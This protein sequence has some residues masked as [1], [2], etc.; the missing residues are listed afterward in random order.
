MVRSAMAPDR[1]PRFHIVTFFTE[2]A[3]FDQGIDLADIERE[4]RALVEP[5]VDSYR[6]YAPRVLADDG[7]GASRLVADYRG[8]LDQHPRRSELGN[9]NPGWARIGFLA[10]K[11]YVLA[12][13]LSRDDLVEG[14]IVMYH[15]VDVRKYPDYRAH[16]EHWRSVSLA[17]LDELGTDVFAPVGL[18][19]GIDVKAFLVEK[20]LDRSYRQVRGVWAGLVVV[21]KSAMSI[22]FVEAWG[23]MCADLDDIAPLPNPHPYPE[24]AWHSGD[25]AVLSVLAA[26]WR[27]SGRLPADWPRFATH[28]RRYGLTEI[29]PRKL[30]DGRLVGSLRTT[31]RTLRSRPETAP[32]VEPAVR[33]AKGLRQAIRGH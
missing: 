3:P 13:E 26:T 4:F 8:W 9:Y 29:Y 1:P 18:P 30:R 11:P 31:Y 16:V 32:I 15:D 33:V 6:A 20:Y 14:D 12:R 7:D 10:W 19:M 28:G 22:E 5:S 23:R 27:R 24:A 25:Q 21:R 17:I 2:G